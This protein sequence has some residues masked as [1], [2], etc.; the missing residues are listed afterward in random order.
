MQH[1]VRMR[2]GV[3]VALFFS[4]HHAHPRLAFETVFG[5]QLSSYNGTRP[6]LSFLQTGRLR[7]RVADGHGAAGERISQR[8]VGKDCRVAA[9]RIGAPMLARSH[10]QSRSGERCTVPGECHNFVFLCVAGR[11]EGVVAVFVYACGW[12]G[13]E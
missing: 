3:S 5:Y 4:P 10:G 12:V 13:E 6:A 2:C 9:G 8:R 11:G 1:E 7:G